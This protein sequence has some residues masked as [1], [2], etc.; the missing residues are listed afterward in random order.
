MK[1]LLYISCTL[2]FF[3]ACK[4][5]KNMEQPISVDLP[6]ANKIANAHGFETWKNVSEVAF[7]FAKKRQW[8]WKPKTHDITLITRTDT[9]SYNKKTVDS[10]PL[11][12][13][14]AFI[15]DKFWLLIPFQLLWDKGT[16]ISEPIKAKAPVSKKNMNKI[17]VS[18][19]DNVG[20]T[21]GDAY[22]I[23]FENDYIIK[24]WIFRRGNGT[25]PSLINTFENYQD[26]N[27]IKIA[28]DH[29]KGEGDWNLTLTEVKITLE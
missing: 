19:A 9:I 28:Q 20:Y 13:D 25:A 26:F 27:G 16:T 10:L 29:K 18:Y 24:E 11:G 3:I 5:Q 7:T 21:P 1:N 23:F 22:D 6:I 12:T 15:N 17:T 14:K 8:I 4:K 2:L